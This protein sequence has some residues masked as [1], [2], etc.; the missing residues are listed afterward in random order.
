MGMVEEV[1]SEI[2]PSGQ[3]DHSNPVYGLAGI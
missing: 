3:F 2:I 1:G